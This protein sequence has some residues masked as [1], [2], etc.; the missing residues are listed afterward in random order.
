MGSA[1]SSEDAIETMQERYEQPRMDVVAGDT[2]LSPTDYECIN[3]VRYLIIILLCGLMLIC[4][5]SKLE[6][7][8]F[9]REESIQAYLACD[10]NEEMAVNLLLGGF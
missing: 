6:G 9:G 4:G 1:F 10:K 8:G 7:M 2:G 5:I 3:R